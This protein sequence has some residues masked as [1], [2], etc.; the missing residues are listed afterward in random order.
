[1]VP[2][3][4][5][6]CLSA[7]SH[8]CPD[9]RGEQSFGSAHSH[10]RLPG[11]A[12][13]PAVDSRRST[14]GAVLL[15]LEQLSILLWNISDQRWSLQI[16]P[17]ATCWGVEE[18]PSGRVYAQEFHPPSIYAVM[19]GTAHGSLLQL[20]LLAHH[21]TVV[22]SRTVPVCWGHTSLILCLWDQSSAQQ[23]NLV[24]KPDP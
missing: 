5:A 20:Y 12:P 8:T 4:Y 14:P 24:F 3:S 21:P 15:H 9:M 7:T 10:G 22:L 2:W 23:A 16:D 13:Q 1:M 6:I 18:Q 11:S 19:Q 17:R